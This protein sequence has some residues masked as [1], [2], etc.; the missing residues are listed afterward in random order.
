MTLSHK[1]AACLFCLTLT[2]GCQS[3]GQRGVIA[4]YTPYSASVRTERKTAVVE[5]AATRLTEVDETQSTVQLTSGE[6]GPQP[7]E[8][9]AQGAELQ[10]PPNPTLDSDPNG[11]ANLTL[12]HLE[13]LA[14]E[15]NPA[16]RQAS[17]SAHKGMGL[18]DQVGLRPNPTLEYNGEQL[19]DAGTDQHMLTISQDFVTANKLGWNQAVLDRAVQAQL[20]E[21][22]VQRRRV[23]TDVRVSYFDALA[24]QRRLELANAFR[25]V[26]AKGVEVA[27]SR[28][29]AKE[30]SLPEVL[31]TEIQLQ[32]VELVQQQAEIDLDAAWQ[33]LAANVGLPDLLMGELTGDL[34]AGADQ[35]DWD[36]VYQQLVASTPEIQAATARIEKA[37]A[38]CQRQGVQAI[39]N[40]NLSV[41]VGTDLGT[42]SEFARVGVGVPLPLHNKNQGNIAAAQAE[43]CRA[44]QDL[45]RLRMA[46]KARLAR[47]A[48]G[49]DSALA[50]VNRYDQQILPKARQSL[51]LSE[52]AYQ[53]GEFDFLQVLIAR[54]TFFD[55]N[56]QAVDARRRLAQASA[57]TDGMLLSGGLSETPDLA[58][59]DGLRGQ[60]LDQK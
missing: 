52:E 40:F 54:R 50:A 39:P 24:A 17:A 34:P 43:Y 6:D 58:D 12:A 42:G 21:V 9:P 13:Q 56:L 57:L 53:A 35:R 45:E 31:Q 30:G 29:E 3:P 41:G 19:G 11:T 44:I 55:A 37:S 26:V 27:Q 48:Q 51:T 28:K 10:L 36:S 23:L 16:I 4:K 25:D 14:L 20:W 32:E 7:F 2:L 46:L 1:T 49:H 33:E 47:A 8:P 5:N 59:D 22:E 38:N 60:A 15:N 18:R